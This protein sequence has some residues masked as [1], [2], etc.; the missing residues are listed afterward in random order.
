MCVQFVSIHLESNGKESE[1]GGGRRKRE[2]HA[3]I[4]MEGWMDV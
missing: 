4:M 2:S 3:E 1:A